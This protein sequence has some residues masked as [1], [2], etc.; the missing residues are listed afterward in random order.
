MSM[1]HYLEMYGKV[2][3]W[4]NSQDV[5][6]SPK[7]NPLHAKNRVYVSKEGRH[8][9]QDLKEQY[10]SLIPVYEEAMTHITDKRVC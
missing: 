9:S 10:T 1:Q 3:F 4:V 2:P 7:L 8:T 6:L 5:V